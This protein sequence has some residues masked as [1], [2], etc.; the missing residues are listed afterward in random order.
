MHTGVDSVK[1][2]CTVLGTVSFGAIFYTYHYAARIRAQLR[3]LTALNE[4]LQ[5]K[6]SKEHHLRKSERIGRTRAER[7]LRLT[8]GTLAA[9]S[10]ALDTSTPTAAPMPERHIVGL[11]PYMFTPIGRVA[12]CFSQRNGTPRQPLLVEAAR[13]ELALAAWVPPAAL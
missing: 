1:V 8:Q 10:D 9:K 5:D 7:E 6:L 2:L 3:E 11:Q 4:E 12:S 13:A